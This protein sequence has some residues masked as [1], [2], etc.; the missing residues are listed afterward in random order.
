MGSFLAQKKHI[1]RIPSLSTVFCV[2]LCVLC[3]CATLH[4]IRIYYYLLF[5]IIYHWLALTICMREQCA[6][7][8]HSLKPN[9]KIRDQMFYLDT[10]VSD[11]VTLGEYEI[12]EI[13]VVSEC[14]Q[15][16][17]GDVTTREVEGSER[18]DGRQQFNPCI[19]HM[20]TVAEV[21]ICERVAPGMQSSRALL[22]SEVNCGVLYY[23]LK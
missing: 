22:L 14:H 12:L 10:D 8:Q 16:H 13:S 9:F 23:Y 4:V 18:R 17:I 21:R 15:P 2:S 6:L 5:I 19:C 20:F 1:V 11:S 3:W 7:Q